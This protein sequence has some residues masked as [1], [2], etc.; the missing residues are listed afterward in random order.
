MK[1]LVEKDLPFHRYDVQTEKA[2]KEFK[3]AGFEDKVRLLETSGEAYTDYYTLGDTADYFYGKLVPSTG[4]LTV[5]DIQPYHDG[6]LLRVPS[7][8]DP[9]KVADFEDQPK[10][11]EMFK[12]ALRWNIIMGESPAGSAHHRS[13]LVR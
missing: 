4:Y 6:L 3:K 2:I 5:W 12:E 8:E 1:E 7:R 9:T 10:T 11:F 13:F